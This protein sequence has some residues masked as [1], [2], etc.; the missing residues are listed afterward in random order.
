MQYTYVVYTIKVY[1]VN[2]IVFFV[3]FIPRSQK[4]TN[5]L[6]SKVLFRIGGYRSWCGRGYLLIEPFQ[7]WWRQ[8][9]WYYIGRNLA[10]LSHITDI[11][12]VIPP[13]FLQLRYVLQ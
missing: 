3:P 12:G 10:R 6:E 2:L 5:I 11:Q 9:F 8:D 13:R 4:D 7:G 1:V